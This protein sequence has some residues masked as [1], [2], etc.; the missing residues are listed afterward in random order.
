[1]TAPN[2]FTINDSIQTDA[3]INHGNSGGPLLDLDGK[4]VGVNAQIAERLG[5]QRRH[6]LRDPVEHGQVDRL[7]ADRAVARSQHAY[8]GVGVGTAATASRSNEVKPGTPAADAN[9]QVGD[10]ITAIGSEQVTDRRHCRRRS[11]LTSR[12]TP[13]R[14][15]TRATGRPRR[16]RSR[17]PSGRPKAGGKK[18]RAGRLQSV[19]SPS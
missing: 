12:A 13:S 17:W 8:L 11:T 10:V 15:A 14:S 9:L 16:R 6:R 1:M 5:R 2:N 3:A 18:R 7:A 19:A 4:V